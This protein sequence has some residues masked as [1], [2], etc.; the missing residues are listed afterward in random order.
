MTAPAL[1]ERVRR[2]FKETHVWKCLCQVGSPDPRCE[3]FRQ[4]LAEKVAGWVE[5]L[6]IALEQIQHHAEVAATHS[7][8]HR[9]AD[10]ALA[11]LPWRNPK[12]T[13]GVNPEIGDVGHQTSC[14]FWRK[15][16][17]P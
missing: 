16:V 7:A 17:T 9:I 11:A 1:V 8:I 12:C 14:P 4:A 13:C 2:E 15:A 10:D 5:G 6:E 3:Q